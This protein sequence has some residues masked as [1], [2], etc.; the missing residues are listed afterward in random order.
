MK[1]ALDWHDE[2]LV[3]ADHANLNHPFSCPQCLKDVTSARGAVNTAHFRHKDASPGCPDYHPGLGHSFWGA[4]ADS[5]IELRIAVDE[6]RWNLYLKL[7]DLTENE[8]ALTSVAELRSR[9][10]AILYQNGEISRINGLCLWPGSGTTTVAVDPANQVRRVFTEGIWPPKSDRWNQEAQQIPNMGAV[11]GQDLGGDYRMCT[12]GRPLYLGRTA[13]WVSSLSAGPPESLRP[14]KLNH[15]NGFTAWKFAV[16][17][18]AL[19]AARQ[20]LARMGIAV[21]DARDP[22]VVLTPPTYYRNDGAHVI[23]VEDSPIVAPSSVADV[24][25][26]EADG[27]FVALRINAPGQ[28]ARVAGGSG[29]IRIRTRSGDVVHIERHSPWFDGKFDVPAWSLH[30][31]T[32]VCQPYSTLEV[33]E[34]GRLNLTVTQHMPL[35][36]SAIVRYPDRFSSRISHIGADALDAWLQD[37][38]ADA[39]FL[40]ISASS[41]GV[42]RVKRI[43]QFIEPLLHEDTHTSDEVVS[44]DLQC[45]SP[46]PV[47]DDRQVSKPVRPPHQPTRRRTVW[48]SAYRTLRGFDQPP[49]REKAASDSDWQWRIQR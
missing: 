44:P 49:R 21:T 48:S 47:V 6:V 13:V 45:E 41:F 16:T 35:Q 32:Q 24:V 17:T 42:L 1:T 20:W 23:H 18:K 26:A 7:S 36:F 4:T 12:A 27:V 10:I 30:N 43:V 34:I 29:T 11:F 19:P 40:E 33:D 22:T 2:T 37:V 5:R 46:P 38:R 3:D 9:Q 25:V 28:L 14:Q 31:G 39:L 15:Q 8:L